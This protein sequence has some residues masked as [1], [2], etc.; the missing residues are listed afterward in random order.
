MS[1]ATFIYTRSGVQSSRSIDVLYHRGMTEPD[2]I[3]DVGPIH[4]RLDGVIVETV[5]GARKHVQ[6]VVGAR[7]TA[8][9]RRFLANW[10]LSSDRTLVIGNFA[11]SMVLEDDTLLSEWLNAIERG[12]RFNLRLIDDHIYHDWDDGATPEED[13]YLKYE[14][15]ITGTETSPETLT[16]NS[17]KLA[18]MQNGDPYP[19]FNS[20]THDFLIAV[21]ADKQCQA[22]FQIVKGSRSVSAGNLSFQIY[23]SDIGAPA[24]SDG[25]YF[26]TIAIF[27]QA[28]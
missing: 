15:E 11:S 18:T 23:I 22:S 13:M 1:N 4:D 6:V 28:K 12:R 19:V 21:N 7:A 17:G 14:V 10:I 5:A 9:D 20:S 3:E 8:A 16:T 27:L 25:K 24:P 2:E 26:A